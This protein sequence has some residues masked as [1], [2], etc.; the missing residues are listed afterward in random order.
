MRDDQFDKKDK[1]TLR[2][3]DN[4]W[5]HY[6][7]IDMSADPK[8][9]H[10]L[11]TSWPL[12]PPKVDFPEL[13]HRSDDDDDLSFV[14]KPI[15]PEDLEPRDWLTLSTHQ[16]LLLQNN[17]GD[18]ATYVII[19][20]HYSLG[21]HKNQPNLH[22]TLHRVS[23]RGLAFIHYKRLWLQNSLGQ[24]FFL[25]KMLEGENSYL[26]TNTDEYTLQHDH[27]VDL[28]LRRK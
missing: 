28:Y 11:F 7:L 20:L 26:T 18:I 3:K 14:S 1:W 10:N 6:R 24:R 25:A 5:T 12:K 19:D 23:I 13:A 16:V 8:Y 2:P 27:Y 9:D 15:D 22:H 17:L 4:S 21:H